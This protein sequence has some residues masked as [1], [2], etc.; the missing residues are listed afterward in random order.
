MLQLE[1]QSKSLCKGRFAF[2]TLKDYGKFVDNKK[3]IQMFFVK[4]V[5]YFTRIVENNYISLLK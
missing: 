1:N 2:F 4:Y 5:F 3:K